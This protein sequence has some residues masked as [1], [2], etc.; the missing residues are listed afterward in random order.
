MWIF[1]S[2]VQLESE[3][4]EVLISPNFDKSLSN[5]SFVDLNK[6]SNNS[7]SPVTLDGLG[8]SLNQHDHTHI[9]TSYDTPSF[10]LPL[11]QAAKTFFRDKATK[12]IL[13]STVN[14]NAHA[15]HHHH[16]HN[17]HHQR[18]YDSSFQLKV[19]KLNSLNS[20]C[21][22]SVHSH[23]HLLLSNAL[24]SHSNKQ[25]TTPRTPFMR[26]S[27]V[28]N[29]LNTA[30]TNDSVKHVNSKKI[31][32]LKVSVSLN[33]DNIQHLD[34]DSIDSTIKLSNG[35]HR[36]FTKN[37]DSNNN[38]NSNSSSNS[39]TGA[40]GEH[41]NCSES[42]MLSS[43]NSSSPCESPQSPSLTSSVSHS[44]YQH[45]SH[46]LTGNHQSQH[47]QSTSYRLNSMVTSNGIDHQMASVSPK[48]VTPI[49][50]ITNNSNNRSSPSASVTS[51]QMSSGKSV[52]TT[53]TTESTVTSN[54][55]CANG[56]SNQLDHRINENGPRFGPGRRDPKCARCQNHNVFIKVKGE[57]SSWVTFFL[58]LFSVSVLHS[59]QSQLT[60]FTPLCTF[61][62]SSLLYLCSDSL[63]SGHKLLCPFK[64][65][66]CKKCRL[67]K[68]RQR[69]MAKQVKVRRAQTSY[70]E[71]R[72]ESE[73]I[74]ALIGDDDIDDG[75]DED[76]VDDGENSRSEYHCNIINNI[77][78][79]R[80]HVTIFKT[81]RIL[82]SCH[83]F[84]TTFFLSFFLFFFF[85]FTS[86]P[87]FHLTLQV[88][89]WCII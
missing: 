2:E 51:M 66:R 80:N 62:L 50:K 74:D 1:F 33:D 6:P 68:K 26:S 84:S 35:N 58:F 38:S 88:Y 11:K 87:F 32:P 56:N 64:N 55:T 7:S 20:D 29:V 39:S 75:D 46:H 28:Y 57:L 72:L 59:T 41:I 3:M 45:H 52:S 76:D 17:H 13:D 54:N 27:I 77:F 16:H 53:A 43:P 30:N 31:I 78:K 23:E 4:S 14:D 89:H 85:F 44:N 65:C 40:A 19:N 37:T 34:S 67:V 10:R 69:I 60:W 22:T 47:Q 81:P 12:L 9:R 70:G 71:N 49:Q 83:C 8:R 63:L 42:T 61:I 36:H 48:S 24:N 25:S 5:G 18:Q 15:H 86:P 82:N 73:Q 21:S 79:S